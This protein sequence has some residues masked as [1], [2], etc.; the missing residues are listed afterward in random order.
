MSAIERLID[1]ANPIVDARD[2]FSDDDMQALLTLTLERNASMDAQEL[3]QPVRPDERPPSRWWIAA[4]AFAAIVIAVGA[5]VLLLPDTTDSPP[6]TTPNQTVSTVPP[7]VVTTTDGIST[8]TTEA[9]PAMTETMEAFIAAFPAA[10]NSRDLESFEA[11]FDPGAT[12]ASQGTP[13]LQVNLD[14]ML[15]EAV[16]LWNQESTIALDECV[17]LDSGVAC[18]VSRSGPVELGLHRGPYVARNFFTLDDDGK[19]L[20]ILLGPAN[21][22]GRVKEAFREWLTATHPDVATGLSGGLGIVDLYAGDDSEIYL[23][24]VPIWADLGRPTP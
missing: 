23:E 13:D 2:E 14:R 9:E 19:I 20:S 16:D 11:M 5:A 15:T 18:Q 1:E 21:A 17:P 3:T 10:F 6:A 12:R 22:D 24:W 8:T 4:V 7:T